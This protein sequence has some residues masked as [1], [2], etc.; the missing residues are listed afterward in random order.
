MSKTF[1]AQLESFAKLTKQNLKYVATE[2]IQDTMEDATES[3]AG[4]MRG[5][6]FEVGK[7]PVNMGELLGSLS[8]NGG[9]EGE[10]SYILAIGGYVLGDVMSFAWTAEH[11][12]AVELGTSTTLGRHFVGTAARRFPEYVE[13]RAREFG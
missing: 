3:V 2:S 6:T 1:T 9:P 12:L 4:V 7:L 10:N 13:K 5:G 8:S 11:A